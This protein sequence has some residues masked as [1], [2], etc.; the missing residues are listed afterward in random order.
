MSTRPHIVSWAVRRTRLPLLAFRCVHC[1]PGLAD[2]TFRV[3]ANRHLL[4]LWLLV[5]CVRRDR[6]GKVTAYDRVPVRSPD[7]ILLDP[8]VARRNR[9]AL[10]WDSCWEPLAPSP[11]ECPW[12][13]QGSAIIDDPVPL[14]PER[15]IAQGTGHQPRGNRS[16][17]QDRHS[18]EPR[19]RQAVLVR[20]AV[21][22]RRGPEPGREAR[23][24]C[25][26]PHHAAIRARSLM[27]GRE[28]GP[29]PARYRRRR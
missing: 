6:T 25:P 7:P 8:L 18:A 21:S 27:T 15:L 17:H 2:E 28:R 9:F 16:P 22:R 14:R 4:D 5:A 1:H 3:K 10:G 26:G 19:H 12:P 13:V 23:W 24:P 11:P 20:P 29:G